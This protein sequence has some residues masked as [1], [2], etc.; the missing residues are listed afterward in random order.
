MARDLRRTQENILGPLL[1]SRDRNQALRATIFLEVPSLLPAEQQIQT[2]QM[3]PTLEMPEEKYPQADWTHIF[4]DG[5]VKILLK[6]II[7]SGV[8]IRTPTGQT[9]TQM[10]QAEVLKFQSRSLSTPECSSLHSRYET[11]EDC[12]PHRLLSSPSVPNLQYL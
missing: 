11:T 4:T 1:C 12:H 2:Q 10:L 7:G 9:A 6:I 8:F 3:F 5:S